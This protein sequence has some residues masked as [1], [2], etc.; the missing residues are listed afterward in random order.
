M[1]CEEAIKRSPAPVAGSH[2]VSRQSSCSP[3]HPFTKMAP[4]AGEER[5]KTACVTGGNGYIASLLIKMLLE[6]GYVV[7]TTVR[8]PGEIIVPHCLIQFHS[9]L[10][11]PRSVCFITPLNLLFLMSLNRVPEDKEAN[12]HLEDLK[13]LGTL[14]VFRADL[15]EEGSYDEAVAGCDYAF[16][17]AAPVN[18]TSTNPEKELIE[19]G[20]QGTLNVMRSCAKAGTVKRVILTSSTA[21]VSSKPLDGDGHVL[22]EE[23]FSDV[24]YLTAKRTGLWA[25][26]VSKVLMEKAASKFAEEHGMDLVTVCPSVTVG[27]APDRQVYTTVPAILSLLSGDEAELAVLKGIERA[28]GSVP[29]VHVHDVCRAEIFVAETPEVAAGRYICNALDTTIVDMA[30]FL[31]D[32]YPQYKVNTD[33]SGELLAKPIALLPST[34]MEKDGFEFKYKTLEHI[35]DDMVEYGKTLG[36]L[37]N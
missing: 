11:V 29:L 24:E 25:Y 13:K 9:F 36:I 26:P 37:S 5:K 12:S 18:Y 33:L 23:S 34:K 15:A 16:L 14:E 10:G 32:T 28:S 30:R 2:R 3:T 6:K 20:V 21:A 19:L 1:T 27:E 4:A 31:A 35:Y 17:L 8:H 7:K 22:D